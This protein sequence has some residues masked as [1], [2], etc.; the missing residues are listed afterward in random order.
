MLAE[1]DNDALFFGRQ[2]TVPAGF[3]TARE[4]NG[5][6]AMLP[7]GNRLGIDAIAPGQNSKALIAV[8]Y[9]TTFLLRGGQAIART[10]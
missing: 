1:A 4:V 2:F 6:F 5:F 10:L 3:R 9:R 7:F 8:A